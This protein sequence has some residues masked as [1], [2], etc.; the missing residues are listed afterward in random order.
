L[1]I[2][3]KSAPES[4]ADSAE[5][6]SGS[7]QA[8]GASVHLPSFLIRATSRSMDSSCGIFF[9]TQILFL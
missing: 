2:A 8:E 9:S 5:N 6:F 7:V 1:K 3:K 4:G